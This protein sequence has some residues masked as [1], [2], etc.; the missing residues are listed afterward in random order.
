MTAS[1]YINGQW[2]NGEG[3]VFSSLN[4]FNGDAVWS[5]AAA[6]PAQVNA[7][8]DAARAAAQSW[9]EVSFSDRCAI[10]RQYGEQ[11]AE[12]KQLI[13][14]TIASET[15]KPLWETLTEAAAMAGKIE[16]SIRAYEERTGEKAVTWPALRQCCAT[17]LTG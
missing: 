5:S 12:N 3:P 14:E 8:V 10:V 6:S 11:L 13:A 17:N 7:A 9:A 1:L 15:G 2:L 16:I 4:P